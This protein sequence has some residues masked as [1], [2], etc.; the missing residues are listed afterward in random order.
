MQLPMTSAWLAGDS[1]R[2]QTALDLRTPR[3]RYALDRC[4]GYRV[5]S[6]GR[7]LG[8]VALVAPHLDALV[9]RTGGRGRTLIVPFEQVALVDVH[10]RTV[11][12]SL[13]ARGAA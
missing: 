11:V 2:M 6:G 8:V 12:L 4:A 7:Q 5:L 13:D 3:D 9:V 10:E 1:G